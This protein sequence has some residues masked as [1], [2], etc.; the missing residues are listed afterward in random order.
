[1][2]YVLGNIPLTHRVVYLIALAAADGDGVKVLEGPQAHPRDGHQMW[3]KL[4]HDGFGAVKGHAQVMVHRNH[5][6][7]VPTA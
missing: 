6:G 1:M 5:Q 2:Y 3:A 4:H 7:I